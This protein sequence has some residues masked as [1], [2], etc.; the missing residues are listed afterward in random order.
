MIL[1]VLPRDHWLERGKIFRK[2][3]GWKQVANA[4]PIAMPQGTERW[5]QEGAVDGGNQR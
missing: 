2:R 1:S 4:D 3:P 5:Q